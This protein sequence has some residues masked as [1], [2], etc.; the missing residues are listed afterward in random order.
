MNYLPVFL[1]YV[2][3][4][5]RQHMH[6]GAPPH[7]LRIVGQ[8]L[9]QTFAEQWIGRE[10][11]VNWPARTPD[12]NHLDFWLWGYLNSWVYAAP[13]NDL[14]PVLT[15]ALMSRHFCHDNKCRCSVIV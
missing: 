13:I 14:S 12:L 10:G 5:Q 1:E 15:M 9:N 11:P 8:H 7:F 6:D 2:A 3:L 4:H